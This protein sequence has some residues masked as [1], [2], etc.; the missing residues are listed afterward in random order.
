M[1]KTKKVGLT[2]KFGVRYGKRI[3]VT[4]EKIERKQKQKYKCPSCKKLAVKRVSAGIWQCMRCKK[5]FAGGAYS[6]ST[7]L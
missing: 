1:T 4:Y 3:K 7:E 5:K 2:G 6:P